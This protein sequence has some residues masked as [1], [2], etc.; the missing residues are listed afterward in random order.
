SVGPSGG[1]GKSLALFLNNPDTSVLLSTN[2][3]L[4]YIQ[5]I[6]DHIEV[7]VFQ[8]IPFD[9][10]GDSLLAARAEMF[11]DGF[12]QYNLPR[13]IM[14]FRAILGQLN[15]GTTKKACHLLDSRLLSRDYGKLFIFGSRSLMHPVYLH[16]TCLL[17]YMHRSPV[18]EH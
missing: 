5:E 10:P 4:P 8:K 13:A 6:E 17:L 7:I 11:D 15:Q 3:V 2:Q 1:V 16:N 12:N 18:C 9:P 14:K